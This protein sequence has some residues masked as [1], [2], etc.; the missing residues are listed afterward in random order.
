MT[1]DPLDMQRLIVGEAKGIGRTDACAAYLRVARHRGEARLAGGRLAAV[2]RLG[3]GPRSQRGSSSSAARS[4]VIVDRVAGAQ[5]GVG[6]A[7]GDVG[8]E[9]RKHGARRWQQ[10]GRQLG[11]Q[12][13]LASESLSMLAFGE[14]AEW[15]ARDAQALVVVL[16]PE[17]AGPAQF[18]AVED[19]AGSNQLQPRW[20]T[21]KCGIAETKLVRGQLRMRVRQ[22]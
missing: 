3:A 17:L 18:G 21:R 9:A 2:R 19:R 1:V 14:H 5:R 15:H 10:H 12:M 6:F 11:N 16:L 13:D 8:V 20:L 7:V 4:A 22:R